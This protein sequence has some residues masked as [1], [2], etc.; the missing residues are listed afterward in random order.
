MLIAPEPEINVQLPVPIAGTFAAIVAELAQTD[1]V[2][3]ALDAVG[4]GVLIMAT[5][6]V[7]GGHTPL[8]IVHAKML[9][10]VAIPVKP[11]FVNVGV[12][13]VAAPETKLQVP[14]P[15]TGVFPFSVAVLAHMV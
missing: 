10:P 2:G 12:V 14:I 6:D 1:C 4:F 13:I 9:V 5:V 8:L 11:V 15:I 7:E 3:P